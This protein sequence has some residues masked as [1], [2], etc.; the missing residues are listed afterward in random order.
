MS[1]LKTIVCGFIGNDCR[2]SEYNGQSILNWSVAYSEKYK[3]KEGVQQEH[4]TW[5]NCSW[6]V[7][8]TTIA[9]YLKKGTLIIAE[10]VPSTNSYQDKNGRWQAD[11][12]LRVSQ[13]KLLGGKKENEGSSGTQNQ[14]AGYFQQTG[15]PQGNYI[16]PNDVTE[17]LS[18]LPF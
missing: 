4:T 7:D 16:N 3:N 14:S 18:D 11:F 2:V 12:K 10:G 9:Q 6:Y 15:N 5:V 1:Y 13:V 8:K 17:P